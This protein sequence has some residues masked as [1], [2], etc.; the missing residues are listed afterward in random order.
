MRFLFLLTLSPVAVL[1]AQRGE[2]VLAPRS[3][4]SQ[5]LAAGEEQVYRL[6][7]PVG[8]VVEVSIREKQ[9][10]AGILAVLGPDGN[11]VAEVDPDRARRLSPQTGARQ[12]QSDGANR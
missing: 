2:E 8:Q 5:I 1:F 4:V 11:E 7:V 12:S 6:R 9:G 10:M 3:T